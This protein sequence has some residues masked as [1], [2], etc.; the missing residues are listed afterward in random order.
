VCGAVVQNFGLEVYRKEKNCELGMFIY[1]ND[2]V[3]VPHC[4]HMSLPSSRTF[5]RSLLLARACKSSTT[6]MVLQSGAVYT[7]IPWSIRAIGISPVPGW[8]QRS[9]P[10]GE[11]GCRYCYLGM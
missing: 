10:D 9:R 2:K 5:E 11:F 7:V 6:R 1:R 8:Q 3:C 4:R